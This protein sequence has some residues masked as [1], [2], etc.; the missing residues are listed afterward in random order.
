M[1]FDL[2]LWLLI[3]WTC[4]GSYI[5]SINQ[6]WFQSYFKFS[7]E[8]TFT[9][10]AY[11]TTWSQMTFDPDKWPLTHQQMKVPMLHLWPNFGWNP[12]K[13]VE[14]RAK[15]R[16]TGR[17]GVLAIAT[18]AAW[19]WA[20]QGRLLTKKKGGKKGERASWIFLPRSVWKPSSPL[21][22]NANLFSQ[23]QQQQTPITTDNINRGQS[24]PYASFLP[25]QATQGDTKSKKL[26]YSYVNISLRKFWAITW[27]FFQ[28][29]TSSS[30]WSKSCDTISKFKHFV[31]CTEKY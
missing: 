6:V 15:H 7:N 27:H 16:R 14:G 22:P 21:E 18:G 26:R 24:N 31:P 5:I 11:L 19:F 2:H 20:T 8:A 29:K 13:H 28:T 23:Q 25:N 17:C 4:E 9:F 10:S 30:K 1:T 3:S 12:S